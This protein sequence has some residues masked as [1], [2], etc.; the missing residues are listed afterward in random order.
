M[1]TM[2]ELHDLTPRCIDVRHLRLVLAIAR[3]GSVTRAAGRLHLSQSA[4]S[5]QLLDLERELATR[6]FDRVGKRMVATA[7]GARMVAAAAGLLAE[8]C[9][10]EGSIAELR[11]A[12]K[13]P[14]RITTS[15]F[16]S[17]NWLPAA[18]AHFTDR[19]PD[20]ELDIVLEATRRAVPA[21]LADEVD[22]AIVTDPPRD[23]T[24]Q[25]V[26]VAVSE[27]IAVASPEHPVVARARRGSLR[28]GAL[29]DCQILVYDISDH[30]LARL[31]D[32]VRASWHAESG[33]RLATP[34]T[35]RKIPLSEALLELVRI[36]RGVGIVDRWTVASQ[37]GR[38]LVALEMRPR[39]PRTFFAVWRKANPRELPMQELIKVIKKAGE[40]AVRA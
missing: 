26:E 30:D 36:G 4:V 10:L 5:H 6:L 40:R 28:W 22:L 32:G 37:L 31:N 12:T 15:C 9:A 7:P 38:D 35:V 33:R 19:H 11:G 20:V 13:I 16:T 27:L 1:E 18:L 3:E 23:D 21:L 25:R 17:Y 34:L 14:L 39:A 29:H 8:L 24:W 2:Q